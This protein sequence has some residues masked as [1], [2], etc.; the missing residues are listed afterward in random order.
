MNIPKKFDK[1]CPENVAA[2]AE[3]RNINIPR[4]SLLAERESGGQ[5][6]EMRQIMKIQ[7]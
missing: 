3:R 1:V 4:F 2:P 5:S 7:S 6:A